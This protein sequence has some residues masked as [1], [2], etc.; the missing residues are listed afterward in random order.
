MSFTSCLKPRVEPQK[1]LE[2]TVLMYCETHSHQTLP[3]EIERMILL[4]SQDCLEPF[5]DIEIAN[6]WK[7]DHRKE[8][9]VFICTRFSILLIVLGC[10]G[11]DMLGSFLLLQNG[12]KIKSNVDKYQNTN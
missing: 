10:L 9:I 11:M 8:I 5:W 12:K 2:I 4:Y 1:L 3:K 7:C 6:D